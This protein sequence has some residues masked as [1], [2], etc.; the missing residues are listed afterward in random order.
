MAKKSPGTAEIAPPTTSAKVATTKDEKLAELLRK[1]KADELSPR[2]YHE[3]RA[4][5]LAEP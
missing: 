3:Q 1:Y 4:K 5:I 2:E